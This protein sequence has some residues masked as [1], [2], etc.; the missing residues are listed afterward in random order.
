MQTECSL[1]RDQV[2]YRVFEDA[3]EHTIWS[4]LRSVLN[5]PMR[6]GAHW[7][8]QLGEAATEFPK[9]SSELALGPAPRLIHSS[10]LLKPR[11]SMRMR[12]SSS[13]S[14][15]TVS[16]IEMW[17]R[18]VAPSA[19]RG[20]WAARRSGHGA[21]ISDLRAQCSFA[22]QFNEE[23]FHIRRFALFHFPKALNNERNHFSKVS[24]FL[25]HGKR[26]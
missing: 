11:S 20:A 23:T 10:S 13:S 17:G 7:C 1:R 3:L 4:S 8:T 21:T 6:V 2:H 24:R 16:W 5:F 25:L 22:R 26:L 19:T 18:A 12:S 9:A 15:P 14:W